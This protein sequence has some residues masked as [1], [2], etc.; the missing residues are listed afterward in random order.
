MGKITMYNSKG[1]RIDRYLNDYSINWYCTDRREFHERKEKEHQEIMSEF[2]DTYIGP[3]KPQTESRYD[4]YEQMIKAIG[5]GY[6][7]LFMS[8]MKGESYA[9][10]L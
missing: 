6:F 10:L 3:V 8:I 9:D 2:A 1:N 4:Y 5:P 7:A